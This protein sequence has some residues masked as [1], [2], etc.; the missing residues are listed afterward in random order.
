[1]SAKVSNLGEFKEAK[2][3][4][5]AEMKQA[6]A[7]KGAIVGGIGFFKKV[8]KTMTEIL[9]TRVAGPTFFEYLYYLSVLGSMVFFLY[10][11]MTL[12][13]K[14]WSKEMVLV[15]DTY[16]KTLPVPDLYFCMMIPDSDIFNGSTS[17][18]SP[19][20]IYNEK[21]AGCRGAVFY[22]TPTTTA[23][24]G[25]L[26]IGGDSNHFDVP[27]PSTTTSNLK[28]AT[29][30]YAAAM[31]AKIF[32]GTVCLR[33][34]SKGA[35]FD[36]ST[37]G[38]SRMEFEYG[39]TAFTLSQTATF[40]VIALAHGTDPSGLAKESLNLGYS[41][42]AHTQTNINLKLNKI[43][44]MT[45]GETKFMEKWE[46]GLDTTPDTVVVTAAANPA[47][48]NETACA[49]ADAQLQ[50]N[51]HLMAYNGRMAW[52]TNMYGA[53]MCME[54]WKYNNGGTMAVAGWRGNDA[55]DRRGLMWEIAFTPGS[56]FIKKAILRYPTVGEIWSAVGGAYAGALLMLAL[57]FERTKLVD[58]AGDT[59]AIFKY[60]PPSWREEYLQGFAEPISE[61]EKLRQELREELREEVRELIASAGINIP[62]AG[63]DNTD[64]ADKV[65]AFV[66]EDSAVGVAV[67]P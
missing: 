47:Y 18:P 25:E 32:N 10:T 5:A 26:T 11:L 8:Q 56:F 22:T 2:P 44:D 41:K 52:K 20:M 16:A 64:E 46:F 62:G 59:V 23:C 19:G 50:A 65:K 35:I 31:A 21:K 3:P 17:G 4:L 60:L 36:S 48:T 33:L 37:P 1:M 38:L 34:N 9:A 40:I 29:D 7:A 28:L 57:V 24:V 55:I 45:R 63:A 54:E 42:I 13:L 12:Y 6:N 66:N 67:A 43:K 53:S 51:A 58:E 15:E 49:Y 39:K 61:I 30:P 27:I 14:T